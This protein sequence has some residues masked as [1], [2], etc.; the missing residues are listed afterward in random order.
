MLLSKQLVMTPIYQPLYQALPGLI[1]EG[2]FA[3]HE[4]GF[5]LDYEEQLSRCPLRGRMRQAR[6]TGRAPPVIAVFN[7]KRVLPR[8]TTMY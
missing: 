3:L 6:L 5:P 4:G 2:A 7:P 8:S 1:R